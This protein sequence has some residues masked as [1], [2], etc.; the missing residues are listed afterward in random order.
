MAPYL[1]MV[2][3]LLKWFSQCQDKKH[4]RKWNKENEYAQ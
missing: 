3:Y 1:D 2:K 4:T